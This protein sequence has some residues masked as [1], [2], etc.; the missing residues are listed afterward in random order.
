VARELEVPTSGE[1]VVMK[2]VS[3]IIPSR[4][5]MFLDKTVNDILSKATGE[6]EVIV[7]LDGESSYKI[8]SESKNVEVIKSPVRGMRK[9]TNLGASLATGD[10]F[11]KCDAHCMFSE[12]FD[13]ILK[14]DLED[15]WVAVPR[16]YSLDPEEWSIRTW[17]PVADYHYFVWPWRLK[18]DISFR[19]LKWKDKA[20]LKKDILIDDEMTSQ[21]SCW[22][23][24]K[25]H[26]WKRIEG[27]S[28]ER[29]GDFYQEFHQIGNM[30]WL[31]GGRV[32]VNK[33][34]WYAHL[35]KGRQYGKGFSLSRKSAE[36]S[37]K[38]V[39][40]YWINNKWPNRKYDF[41]WLIDKFWPVPT[42]PENWR[43]LL[44][45]NR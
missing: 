19:S 27:L 37:S 45:G 13:E 33:K 15:N 16:R 9:S 43:S 25:E 30:T 36:Q 18:D 8:P 14:A 2:K 32:V 21:G 1:Q 6:I 26:F 12:G 44:Q 22:I 24:S 3:I 38:F 34:C 23:M 7:I 41:E 39:L 20:E 17:R 4:N 11:M 31:G 40:D 10:Y 35:H 42:W 28:D 5:E 29:Y